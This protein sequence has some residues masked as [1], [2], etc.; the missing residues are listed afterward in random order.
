MT[1]VGETRVLP[2]DLEKTWARLREAWGKT[3][4]QETEVR[5]QNP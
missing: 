2:E 4:I 1:V 3:G 5:S